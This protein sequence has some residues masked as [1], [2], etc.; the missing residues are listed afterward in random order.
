MILADGMTF[1]AA[2]FSVNPQ[3]LA[4]QALVGNNLSARAMCRD[5]EDGS[6]SNY[7]AYKGRAH[8]LFHDFRKSVR[9][10]SGKK[11]GTDVTRHRRDRMTPAPLYRT[12]QTPSRSRPGVFSFNQDWRPK[13]VRK[14]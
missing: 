11:F 12:K 1:V 4:G 8:K 2:W 6:D 14:F 10:A 5:A 9:L 13:D 7:E 3:P